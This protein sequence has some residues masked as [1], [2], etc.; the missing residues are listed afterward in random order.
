VGNVAFAALKI[1][2][3]ATLRAWNGD[4]TSKA[5]SQ[6]MTTLLKETAD[7]HG[8]YMSDQKSAEDGY[9]TFAFAD[10]ASAILW[11]TASQHKA[12]DIEW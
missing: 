1:A 9:M 3:I 6:L 2:G 5:L 10:P 11:A 8:Y 7:H 4:V 12:V